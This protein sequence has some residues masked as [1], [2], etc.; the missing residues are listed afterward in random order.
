MLDLVLDGGIPQ[1]HVVTHTPWMMVG[2]G[3]EGGGEGR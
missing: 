3:E 2:G 1:F